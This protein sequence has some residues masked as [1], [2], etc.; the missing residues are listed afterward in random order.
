MT[1]SH[2][3]QTFRAPLDFTLDDFIVQLQEAQ[4]YLGCS[5]DNAAIGTLVDLDDRFGD[6]KAAL[7]LFI[8]SARRP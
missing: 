6:L 1:S 8:L 2:R 4:I 7:R 5:D 3:N